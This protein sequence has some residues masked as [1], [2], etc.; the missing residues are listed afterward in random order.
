[1]IHMTLI[2]AASLAKLIGR[3][4]IAVVDCRFDLASPSAGRRDYQHG[5]IPGARYADLN[6]DL[7]GPVGAAT[8]RHPLPDPSAFALRL[9]QLGIGDETQI[10]AY[11]AGNGAFAARLWWLARWLGHPQ[12]AV[13]DGG[14]A[15]WT[16]LGHATQSGDAP[17]IPQA[18]RGITARVVPDAWLTS[19]Q[20]VAALKDRRRLLVDARAPE[21]FDGKVEPLDSVAGHV[22]GA[23]NF[24]FG[25]NLGPDGR[26]LA[27]AELRRLWLQF[28]G[29]AGASDVIAMCGSGVTA[30]HNLLALE[31]AGLPGAKLYAGSWSEWIRDPE[32]AVATGS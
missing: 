15:A 18:M 7:S 16:A 19:A 30:C 12:V 25:R 14:F 31:T 1:M 17:E 23:V 26:F 4:G 28:L 20:V 24:P 21:R 13:L 10:I 32:R 11:D 9:G 2:D 3:P 22:P 8:G 29:A 27:A 5:H 6:R